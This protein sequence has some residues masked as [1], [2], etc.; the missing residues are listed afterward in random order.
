MAILK[1]GE[2]YSG[3]KGHQTPFHAVTQTPLL[4]LQRCHDFQATKLACNA[5]WFY[6]NNIEHVRFFENNNI[7]LQD[8]PT[9]VKVFALS[10]MIYTVR[11]EQRD[12]KT[13]VS[14]KKAFL[15]LFC[16]VVLFISLEIMR[17]NLHQYV[18]L[19]RM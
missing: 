17:K 5:V 15:V 11:R 10:L 9:D 2:P 16:Y 7:S 13:S 18:Y 14:Q 3:L 12:N 4:S 19:T 8:R 6:V 1:D